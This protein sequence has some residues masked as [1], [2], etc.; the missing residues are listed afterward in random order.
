MRQK[1]NQKI[2]KYFLTPIGRHANGNQMFPTDFLAAV[3]FG[4]SINQIR[5]I[6]SRAKQE[7][8]YN[9][10]GLPDNPTD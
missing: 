7:G 6:K 9:L 1:R 5:I 3:H 8:W 4:M 2:V 10:N